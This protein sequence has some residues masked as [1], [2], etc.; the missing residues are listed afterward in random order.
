MRPSPLR[1]ARRVAATF[2]TSPP[3]A[4]RCGWP[5]TWNRR[6]PERTSRAPVRTKTVALERIRYAK[7][8]TA[9]VAT[10][11]ID[12]PEELNAF[13]FRTLRE[14]SR[15]FEVASRDEAMAGVVLT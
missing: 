14:L 8:A 11:T 15:A 4:S 10:V 13:D 7:D 9:A 12:R 2:A 3:P 5:M 6:I 1:Q